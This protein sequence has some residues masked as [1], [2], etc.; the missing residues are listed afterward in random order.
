MKI[1]LLLSV[2]NVKEQYVENA[3][4]K[5]RSVTSVWIVLL[6]CYFEVC[7]PESAF[8]LYNGN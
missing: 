1:K 2:P 7:F 4:E 3:Q 6:R 5:L 8:T